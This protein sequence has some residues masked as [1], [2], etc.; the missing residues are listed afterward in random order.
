MGD[1]F[2]VLEKQYFTIKNNIGNL[3]AACQTD[4]Q[5]DAL[6]NA[7]AAARDNYN[8]AIN[9]VFKDND[10]TVAGLRAELKDKQQQIE[11]SLTGLQDI[12]AVI[13]AITA[14]VGVGTKLVAIT[15]GP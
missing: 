13:N 10:L 2:D 4:A 3:L 15:G 11:Q 8:T 6:R 5:R 9:Q 1:T 14:A 7:Y 12:S